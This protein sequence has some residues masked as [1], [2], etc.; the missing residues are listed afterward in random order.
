MKYAIVKQFYNNAIDNIFKFIFKIVDFGKI[1][2]EALWG[3]LEIW[4]SFYMIFYNFFMYFYYLILYGID[5]GA[6]ESRT[7]V[8]FWKRLPRR[9]SSAPVLTIPKG[10]NPI[11]AMY[12]KTHAVVT[13]SAGNV[14]SATKSVV[15]TSVSSGKSF[16]SSSGGK[17]S[18]FKSFGEGLLNFFGALGRI[19]MKPFETFTN[20]FNRK[21]KP[22]REE[23][24]KSDQKSRSLIDEYMKEYER[25]RKV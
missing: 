8:L 4:F 13:Q 22:V 19:F 11:P 16:L 23:E 25:R 12:G 14:L 1:L 10:P 24:E 18:F 6:D 3:F 21:L 2:Y 20:F 15:D 7:T 9:V 5:R 17:R